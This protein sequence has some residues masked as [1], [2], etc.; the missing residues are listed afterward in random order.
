MNGFLTLVALLTAGS[1]ATL[2]ADEDKVPLDQL[3]IAVSKAVKKRFPKAEFVG[4]SKETEDGKTE[5]EVTIKDDGKSIDVTLTSEGTILGMEKE[6]DAENLPQAVIEALESKYKNAKYKKIEEVIKIKDGKE[7][8]EQYEVLLVTAD[9]K[10]V[11]VVLVVTAKIT[12]TEEK[13]E[14]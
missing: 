11:E 1:F 7:K 12:K 14:K 10:T 3:P 2:R 5:Y 4:A 9:K 6:I 8:L 13:K